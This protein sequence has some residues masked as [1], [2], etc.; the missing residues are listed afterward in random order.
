MRAR[1]AAQIASAIAGTAG[2]AAGPPNNNQGGPS[3]R[4]YRTGPGAGDRG[5]S[6]VAGAGAGAGGASGRQVQGN[7]NNVSFGGYGRVG[8]S[9]APSQNVSSG[10][11]RA[12]VVRGEEVR[13]PDTLNLDEFLAEADA[14]DLRKL[15]SKKN[16]KL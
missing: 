4:D 14:S 8:Y 13:K 12:V 16:G 5:G 9:A 15:S 2:T 10:R 1:N 3:G 11:V 6:Y 7:S